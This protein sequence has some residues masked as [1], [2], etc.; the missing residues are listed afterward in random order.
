MFSSIILGHISGSRNIE[1]TPGRCYIG[2]MKRL[3]VAVLLAASAA[4]S[5]WA[6][7]PAWDA[8]RYGSH[9]LEREVASGDGTTFSLLPDFS[10][11]GV[12]LE[13]AAAREP[14]INLEIL[15]RMDIPPL[16]ADTREELLLTMVL[17]AANL[18][19]LNGLHYYSPNRGRLYPLIEEA[20]LVEE[21]GSTER[22][23]G[24]VFSTLPRKERFC[25]Y[26]KDTRFGEVWYDLTYDSGGDY[27][28]LTLENLTVMKA[29]FVPVFQPRSLVIRLFLIPRDKDMLLYGASYGTYPKTMRF[30]VDFQDSFERRLSALQKWV[31]D[32]FF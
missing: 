17:A 2:S 7:D 4:S 24:P 19:A 32:Q 9:Y 28:S 30:A 18:D 5:L 20:W 3:L 14:Q 27:I 25:Y 31:A 8:F 15:Y 13:E 6:Y 21:V 26:Q 29:F 12:F 22:L 1:I 23:P 16:K 11:K 10:G